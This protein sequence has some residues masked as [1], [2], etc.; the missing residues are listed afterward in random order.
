MRLPMSAFELWQRSLRPAVLGSAAV[1]D[2]DLLKRFRGQQDAAAFELLVYRHGPM[3]WATCR[4]VIGNHHLAE[5]AFQACFLALARRADRIRGSVPAWLHRVAVRAGLDL[6]RRV[7]PGELSDADREPADPRPGPFERTVTCETVG[8]VDAAIN[9]LPER[10]RQ[11]VVLCHLQECSLKEAAAELGCPVGTVESRLARARQTLRGLLAGSPLALAVTASVPRALRATTIESGLKRTAVPP[12]IA[13]LAIRASAT[14]W[15][16]A[17]PGSAAGLA[18]TLLVAAVGL[19]QPDAPKPMPK[20]SEPIAKSEVPKPHV[21]SEGV[22]LPR[23]AIARLG[24][25]RFRHSGTPMTG[26]A[27]S[28]DGKLLASGDDRGISVFATQTGQRI[29]RFPL[30][31]GHMPRML[32]FVDDGKQLAIGSGDWNQLAEFQTFDIASGK[33]IAKSAFT[34]KKSQI[35]VIDATADGKCVLVEDRFSKVF[36]W[37]VAAAKEIWS[38]EHPEAAFTMRLTADGK[39]FVEAMSQK[40]ELRD[41]ATGKV[42]TEFPKPAPP[43]TSLYEMAATSADGKLAIASRDGEAVAILDARGS[44]PIK[45]FKTERWVNNLLFSHDGRYL[46]SLGPEGTIVWDTTAD[47]DA[48]PV[49]RLPGAMHGGF[50]PDG[51]TLALADVGYVSLWSVGD[52]K[53]L[54]QSADPSSPVHIA[55]FSADGKSVVGYTQRGWLSWPLDGGTPTRISDNSQVQHEGIASM[56]AD[57]RVGV[58]VVHAPAPG[59]RKGKDTLRVTNFNTGKTL[60]IALE[61]PVW[62]PLQITPDGRFVSANLEGSLFVVWDTATGKEVLQQKRTGKSVQ[63]TSDGKNIVRSVRCVPVE[64]Q[65]LDFESPAYS[66]AF[67][68]DHVTGKEFKLEPMPYSIYSGGI[69]FSEDGT[70]LVVEGRFDKEWKTDGV[71][72]WDLRTHR[73]LVDWTRPAGH[74]ESVRLAPDGRSL[75]IG[76]ATGKLSI[77]EVASGKERMSFQHGGMILSAAFNHDGTKVVASSPEAPVYVWDLLAVAP[78]WDPS[79][80]NALWDD[81]AWGDAKRAFTAMQM[82]RANSS[83]AIAVFRTRLKLPAKPAEGKIAALL[84]QL[85]APKFADREQAQKELTIEAE[86]IQAELAETRKSCS[87]EAGRRVDAI[88]KSVGAPTTDR[89]RSVRVCEILEGIGTPE[90]IQML[91]D[92][93]AG[94][95]GACLSSEATESVAR[96]RR[97]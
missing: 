30:A 74:L 79:K 93:A 40:A 55:R 64:R 84:K 4:R 45:K 27:F 85:D 48:Q 14:G 67:V 8:Q 72:V 61:H 11:A 80:T 37:D 35:F 3:V 17:L 39:A 38:I 87:E 89:L 1:A 75:T 60:K 34:S 70:K 18:A 49:A 50:T 83:E 90:A 47:V 19:G 16:F 9:R 5:D 97:R 92:C 42:I 86:L 12:A 31:A 56:S 94:P 46:A 44:V 66:V 91:S 32:R 6:R 21:D 58:D 62:N 81:L 7:R 25:N 20:T 28:P 71:G 10:L 59:H 82:L 76:D 53:L 68:T 77:V 95:S 41:A 78:K 22:E 26:V 13:S 73:R 69:Q 88:I 43:F 57:G 63:L 29:H 51:K 33:S 96:L 15:G 54:P 24:S 23:G 2:A 36:L 65:G 52:W